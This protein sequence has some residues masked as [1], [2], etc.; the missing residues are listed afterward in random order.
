VHH[1]FGTLRAYHHRKKLQAADELIKV[2]GAPPVAVEAAMF[3]E[4]P[5][6]V[7]TD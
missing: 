1:G 5:G 6:L 4:L 3:L 2:H 7:M